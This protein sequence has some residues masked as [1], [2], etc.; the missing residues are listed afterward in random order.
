MH[1]QERRSYIYIY[2]GKRI[3]CVC[4]FGYAVCVLNRE[5]FFQ[6]ENEKTFKKG[7]HQKGPQTHTKA[8]GNVERKWRAGI[9]FLL[10]T[11][12]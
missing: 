8:G 5:F 7:G 11:E 4:V 9:P 10:K 6:L 1:S 2:T 3:D 12:H